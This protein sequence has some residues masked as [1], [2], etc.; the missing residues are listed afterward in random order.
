ML[1]RMGRNHLGEFNVSS[2]SRLCVRRFTVTAA[3]C[4]MIA[5]TAFAQ[6]PAPKAVAP[7]PPAPAIV[8]QTAPVEAPAAKTSVPKTAAKT[9]S[10]CKGLEKAACETNAACTFVPATT[11]KDGR[12]VKAYCRTKPTRATAATNAATNTKAVTPAK[13]PEAP[14]K[15]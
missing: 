13:A 10:A 8:K 15:N 12:N 11:R 9:A 2:T 14:K 3:A 5:G 4:G 7:A 6:Q 1:Y